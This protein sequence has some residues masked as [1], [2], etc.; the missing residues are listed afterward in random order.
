MGQL[1]LLNLTD[2]L[3]N[4]Y[5]AG[6]IITA[7]NGGTVGMN[8][9]IQFYGNLFILTGRHC[10]HMRCKQDWFPRQLT[11]Q[12]AVEAAAVCLRECLIHRNGKAQL[13]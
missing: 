3:Q 12:I 6:K 8:G 5:H 10:V 7:Q 1:L 2:R 9:S 4:F 13:Q 11:G